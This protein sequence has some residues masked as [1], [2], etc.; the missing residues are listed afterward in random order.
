MNSLIRGL[1]RCLLVMVL[2]TMAGF[3]M[4]WMLPGDPLGQ[5]IEQRGRTPEARAEL[6]ARYALDAPLS[7][8]GL[9]YI[10]GL[11][12][13]DL[14]SSLVDGRPIAGEL[15]RATWL[16][17]QLAIPAL[18][19]A[20]VLGLLVGTARGWLGEYRAVRAVFHALTAIT[21]LPEFML[22]L[23]LLVVL[24]VKARWFPVGG[25]TD[26]VIAYS[27][28]AGARL[29][30][31]MHHLVLPAGSLALTWSA[32]VARQ[33]AIA[34]QSAR[35]SHATQAARARGLA[36]HTLWARY[37]LRVALPSSVTTIGLMFPALISG[38]IVAE[39]IFSW[40]GLGRLIVTG[41][42]SRDYPLA[43]GALLVTSVCL[44]VASVFTEWLLGLADPRVAAAHVSGRTAGWARR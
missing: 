20:A 42:G 5:S 4:L 2:A 15:L 33:Q 37:G 11:T 10:E 26:P 32:I 43:V 23:L 39:T 19:G 7:V 13:G 8:Q 44:A 1:M 27:G 36:P 16:S 25:V 31:R 3:V 6:R 34:T 12:R 30:D 41:I 9:R 14:G 18:L 17:M 35:D 24:A 29:L 38:T 40:P 28:G 21:V 22:A